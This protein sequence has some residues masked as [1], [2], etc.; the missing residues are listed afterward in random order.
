MTDAWTMKVALSMVFFGTRYSDRCL[1]LAG[2]AAFS[3]EMT[4][5]LVAAELLLKRLRNF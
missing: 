2:F 3:I 4:G 5:S 1:K